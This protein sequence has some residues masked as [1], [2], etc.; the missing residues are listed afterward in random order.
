MGRINQAAMKDFDA[1]VP[2]LLP[3][4]EKTADG[5]YRVE[6]AC[7]RTLN[8]P[9]Q[10]D[11]SIHPDGIKDWGVHDQG[12]LREGKRSP[13]DIVMEWSDPPKALED[14]AEWLGVRVDSF[15]FLRP[16]PVEDHARKIRR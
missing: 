11:L 5:G 2:E 13:I 3:S 10:E 4:A 15:R 16:R 14:A 12:D 6:S 9:L 1:W 7:R 8:R